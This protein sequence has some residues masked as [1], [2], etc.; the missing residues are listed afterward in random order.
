MSM[1]DSMITSVSGMN[2]QSSRLSTFSENIANAD[3]VGYKAANAQFST[4]LVDRAAG[5]YTSGGVITRVRYG[6]DQQGVLTGTNNPTD[7]A[8]NGRGFF[9]VSDAAGN[10]HLTRAGSFVPDASGRL[11]NSAG[12]RLMGVPS[13]G[14][15]GAPSITGMAGLSDIRIDTTGLVAAASTKGVFAANLPAGAGSVAPSDLPS[16]NG[17]TAT[18]TEK[19]SLVAYDNLGDKILLDVYLTKT[20]DNTWEA[21]VFDS[22][23]ASVTG[24]GFPYTTG[25]LSSSTL[26]FD[27]TSGKL[28]SSGEMSVVVPGGK[29]ISLDVSSMTQLGA[30]YSVTSATIDGSAPS[31]YSALNVEKDGTIS[32]VYQNGQTSRQFAVAL[33]SAPSIDNLDVASGNVFDASVKSGGIFVGRP[34]DGAFGTIESSTLENATVDM[35]TELTGMIETQRS[36]TANSKAFQVAS[37]VTD[38]L[39]NMKV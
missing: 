15:D 37:D 2:A 11:V 1:F 26:Q 4:M 31:H 10:P 20:A 13:S 3:T 35:A 22:S 21:A 34:G 24:G 28:S 5:S 7:I 9:V 14:S 27:P 19:S 8:I 6:I 39:V 36:Y 17:P 30:A 33:A 23:K 25:P 12:F 16:V 38:V 29:A 32:V 18:P